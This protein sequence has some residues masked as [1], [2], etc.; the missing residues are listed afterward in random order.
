MQEQ[1]QKRLL[2]AVNVDGVLTNARTYWCNFN[3]PPVDKLDPT[4]LAL[5][6]KFCKMTDAQVVIASAWK[7]FIPTAAMWE[8]TF[9]DKGF[10]IPVIDVI[11]RDYAKCRDWFTA[12]KDYI[13]LQHPDA[14]YVLFDDDVRP[15]SEGEEQLIPVDGRVGLGI[16]D[17]QAAADV[18]LPGSPLALELARM[19]KAFGGENMVTLQVGD[20]PVTTVHVREV[21]DTILGAK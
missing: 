12:V 15:G 2:L 18:L 6:E 9:S 10:A 1:T 14:A 13:A 11:E 19:N 5:L 4:A 3:A 17:L 20:G 8:T 21:A 7:V 16:V